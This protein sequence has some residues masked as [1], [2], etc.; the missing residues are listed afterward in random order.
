MTPP[1]SAKTSSHG[2]SAPHLTAQP[3]LIPMC[4]LG[5]DARSQ[6]LPTTPRSPPPPLLDHAITQVTNCNLSPQKLNKIPS[7]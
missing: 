3:V 4:P 7:K 2:C 5:S 6:I 1:P